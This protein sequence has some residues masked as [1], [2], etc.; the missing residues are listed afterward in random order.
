MHMRSALGYIDDKMESLEKTSL[1]RQA[2][3]IL[4]QKTK[5]IIGYYLY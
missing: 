2:S 1:N 5:P 3:E 4:E